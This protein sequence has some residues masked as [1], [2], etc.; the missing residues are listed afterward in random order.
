MR[1]I[2]F[3]VTSS[4]AAISMLKKAVETVS[5]RGPAIPRHGGTFPNK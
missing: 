3:Y 4:E 5:S 1:K 2:N